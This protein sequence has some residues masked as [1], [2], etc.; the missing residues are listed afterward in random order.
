MLRELLTAD[1][2]RVES[3][4]AIGTVLQQVLFGFWLLLYRLVLVESVAADT[5]KFIFAA[6]L[7]LLQHSLTINELG[8]ADW[9]Q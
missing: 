9:V 4:R 7:P 3:I 8:G 6:N 1:I 5:K 2:Q